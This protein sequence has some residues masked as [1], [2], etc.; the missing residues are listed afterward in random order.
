MMV[1][2]DGEGG[3]IVRPRAALGLVRDCGWHCDR[4]CGFGCGCGCGSGRKARMGNLGN[5]ISWVIDIEET[6]TVMNDLTTTRF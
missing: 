2:R 6:I 5:S 4:D 1:S 3:R